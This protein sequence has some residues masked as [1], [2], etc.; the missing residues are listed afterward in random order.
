MTKMDCDLLVMG[1]GPGG[2]AAAFHAA[3]LGLK[4]VIAE[5]RPTLGGVCLNV[6]CIPSKTYLHQAALIREMAGA[7]AGGV[8]FAPPTIDIDAMRAHKDSVV[9]K[10]VTGLGGLAKA[11]QV[12]IVNGLARFG[13]P[14]RAIV[15]GGEGETEITFRHCIV[16]V[17]SEPARLPA[18]PDDPRILDSTSALELPAPSGSL[19]I[20]GGGII[21]LEM[22][23]IY[24][25]LG[26]TVDVVELSDALMPGAD[27][28]L[29]AVWEKENH[30][31]LRDIML[32]TS[33]VSAKA[34]AKGIDVNFEGQQAPADARSYDYVL[35]AVGRRSNGTN[36][37]AEAAGLTLDARG[38][39]PVDVQ[40]RTAV[41]GIFA[42]GDVV[43]GPMLA[44]KA[45]H[46]GH[47]AAEVIAGE[48]LGD[49]AK[50]RVAFDAQVIPS[51]AYTSPEVAWV[52]LTEA[53]A[54]AQGRDIEVS[55]FPWAA[56]G[57]AL[58]N[59]CTNGF[60]KLLFDAKE[61]HLVGGAIVGP[62]AGDMIGEIALA[63]EMGCE[64]EDIALTI[65]PHPTLG[66]TIGLAAEAGLG[67]CTDLPKAKSRK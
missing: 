32:Q 63:I 39:I 47:V 45:T 50:A 62:G 49:A 17:G 48:Q 54:K 1:G 8:R 11:R 55:H 7:S 13:G 60:T 52:G 46:Q 67:T 64:Q 15:A 9:T 26:W 35:C 44:H 23:T 20:I 29:V 65:H 37:S 10:L 2:Y 41:P 21:G 51:V 53:E 12:Q 18:L 24:S 16:A 59:G 36:V 5:Q 38:F 31:H 34:A 4:V 27:R 30:A 66:E 42:I 58:A 6:G 3:D 43:G 25:A 57:R 28:D 56:S 19:L 61:G 40:M 14:S 33:V 22:A